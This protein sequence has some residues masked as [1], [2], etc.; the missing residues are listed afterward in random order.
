MYLQ[1]HP[2]ATP[3]TPPTAGD[4]APDLLE[5]PERTN[6]TVAVAGVVG[7]FDDLYVTGFPVPA[8]VAAPG[9]IWTFVHHFRMRFRWEQD[10]PT[11]FGLLTC[12][13]EGLLLYFL[14][15]SGVVSFIDPVPPAGA[16]W[17]H[18]PAVGSCAW[19]VANGPMRVP[20]IR[21][22]FRGGRVQ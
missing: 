18:F 21:W 4:L 10:G 15:R 3:T 11:L 19:L 17:A 7:P 5:T 6:R 16:F 8:S 12:I 13:P 20:F 14:L 22:R 2:L 9:V 1:G